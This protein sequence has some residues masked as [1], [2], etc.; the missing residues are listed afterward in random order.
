MKTIQPQLDHVL[1]SYG[2]IL[3]E[4]DKAL[5]AVQSRGLDAL[6]A[7]FPTLESCQRRIAEGGDILRQLPAVDAQAEG[8]VPEPLLEER[9]AQVRQLLSEVLVRSGLLESQ[10]RIP[11]R[12]V[13]EEIVQVNKSRLYLKALKEFTQSCVPR[14]RL[15]A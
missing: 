8:Y 9:V 6:D 10:I 11:M 3:S 15:Q 12:A 14:M 1:S 2:D 7:I 5:V 13:T 4:L